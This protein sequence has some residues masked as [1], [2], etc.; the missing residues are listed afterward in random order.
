MKTKTKKLTLPQKILKMKSFDLTTTTI[1]RVPTKKELLSSSSSPSSPSSPPL[2]TAPA[3]SPEP[4][5]EQQPEV[6]SSVI[7]S[8]TLQTP[9][10]PPPSP[11]QQDPLVAMQQLST[12]LTIPI[13]QCNSAANY[14][15]ME[16]LCKIPVESVPY[17]NH[18]DILMAD[19]MTLPKNTDKESFLKSI[20]NFCAKT[21]VD[22][23]NNDKILEAAIKHLQEIFY[24]NKESLSQ[25]F[26]ETPPSELIDG[27]RRQENAFKVQLYIYNLH[28]RD[29]SKVRI[30]RDENG[31]TYIETAL[32]FERCYL[33]VDK[34][35]KS[36]IYSFPQRCQSNCPDQGLWELL[37]SLLPVI[38]D[39]KTT[40]TTNDPKLNE[41]ITHNKRLLLSIIKKDCNL[42]EKTMM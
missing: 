42:K 12:E 13:V 21:N 39:Y 37:I 11:S 23:Q 25:F 6:R 18:W 41:I 2:T 7:L 27:V 20:Y 32:T 15:L 14:L 29:N 22:M 33:L 34:I 9:P 26:K 10:P 31:T 1:K 28:N 5:L 24:Y 30:K 4:I 3:P 16:Q 36:F 8:Q 19:W 35:V 40:T 17:I 38:N